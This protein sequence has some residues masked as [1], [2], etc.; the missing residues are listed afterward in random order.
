M[1]PRTTLVAF[2]ATMAGTTAYV[3]APP[4]MFVPAQQLPQQQQLHS[5]S[6]ARRC[7]ALVAALETTATATAA[8]AKAELLEAIAA[9][10]EATAADGVP[11][12]DFGVTGGELDKDSRAPRDLL[13][14]GAFEAV[15]PRVGAAA[16]R[17]VAAVEAIAAFNPTPNPTAGLGDS[18][19]GEK[20]CKLHGRWY[21]AFTTAADAT[22]SADSKRGDAAVSNIVD[23]GRGRMTNI[24]EFYPRDHPAFVATRSPPKPP[25]TESLNV[26]LSISAASPQRVELIFR[27]VRVQL[28][29][30]LFGFG[31]KTLTLPVPGPFFTRLKFLFRPKKRPPP[32]YFDV[33]YL[34][35]ELR[36]HKTGQGNLFVQQRQPTKAPPRPLA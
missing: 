6:S 21:N 30:K 11:S 20:I 19:E 32:A 10:N 18:K 2:V 16:S 35:D 22:F 34:D 13:E 4:R 14:A 27:R 23:A 33:L 17:V 1:A 25:P 29:N 8:T 9:Y 5:S 31:P 36:V 7:T 3:M 28:S 12:V 26:I 24:I 15:S